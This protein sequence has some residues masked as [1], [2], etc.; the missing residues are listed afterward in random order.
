MLTM[1]DSSIVGH[2]ATEEIANSKLQARVILRGK[3]FTGTGT[4]FSSPMKQS[5]SLRPDR[6]IAEY[7]TTSHP[8]HGSFL[9]SA[10]DGTE[11]SCEFD[12]D[13]KIVSGLCI[14]PNTDQLLAIKPDTGD[15]K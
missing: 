12:V 13:Y 15:H 14:D 9:L 11:L 3:E 10:T 2:G 6:A 7:L 1:P 4:L 5:H 8:K